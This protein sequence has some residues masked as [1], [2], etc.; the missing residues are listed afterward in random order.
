[1]ARPT[2][3][4]PA[5]ASMMVPPGLSQPRRSAS[6]IMA[7]PTRSLTLPPGFSDSTLT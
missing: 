7:R 6:L 3:V 5:V 1:M 4:L 2:P